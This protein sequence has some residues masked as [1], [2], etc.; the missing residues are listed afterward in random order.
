MEDTKQLPTLVGKTPKELAHTIFDILDSKKA[1]DIK[2]LKVEKQT[3][4]TDY[5]I[6]CSGRST[7]QVK[8]LGGELEY[9]TELRGVPPLHFEGRDNNQWV[10]LDYATVLV[11]IFSREAR[12]FYNLE[13]LY[14]DA[15]EI[16]FTTID[17][18]AAASEV[19]DK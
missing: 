14:G 5:F 16:R 7:T 12:E 10:V 17:E 9:Q 1:E 13:K 2:V 19:S 6:I 18:R 15:E 11:H 3:E 4:I 8:S